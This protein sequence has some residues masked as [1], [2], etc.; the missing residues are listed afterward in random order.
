MDN[1]RDGE[2]PTSPFLSV[3]HFSAMTEVLPAE[4]VL[5]L[6][7]LSPPAQYTV[8]LGGRQWMLKGRINSIC[9]EVSTSYPIFHTVPPTVASTVQRSRKF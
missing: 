8:M 7:L 9:S 3:L 2:L 5:E 6:S 4:P 1:W